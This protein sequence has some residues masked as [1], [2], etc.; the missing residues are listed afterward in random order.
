MKERLQTMLTTKI[1][2]IAS[3]GKEF[4]ENEKEKAIE[5]ENN[6]EK[7]EADF[8]T[9][10]VCFD[11]SWNIIKDY[12]YAFYIWVKSL[13]GVQA[14]KHFC[15]KQ[16]LFTIWERDYG[17][18]LEEKAGFYGWDEVNEEWFFIA[19]DMANLQKILENFSKNS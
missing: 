3:D 8:L 14:L 19:D 13:E 11:S 6:L 4:S 15:K 10:I 18:D 12:D 7:L 16:S 2:Y 1:T 17:S 5:H 9:E